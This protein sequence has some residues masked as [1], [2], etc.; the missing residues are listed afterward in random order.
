MARIDPLIEKLL[1]QQGRELVMQ[2]GSIP[3]IRTLN[4]NTSVLRQAVR[5]DRGD[6]GWNR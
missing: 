3:W 6:T 2:A 1:Q 5:C 4:G